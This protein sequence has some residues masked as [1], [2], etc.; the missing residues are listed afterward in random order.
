[1][2]CDCPRLASQQ[3][4]MNL[5]KGFPM[6]SNLKFWDTRCLLKVLAM[7]LMTA[8]CFG[9]NSLKTFD[10]KG[11]LLGVGNYQL[12]FKT[13]DGQETVAYL[14]ES[15]SSF[16]YKGTAEPTALSP[17]LM[18]RFTGKFDAKGN[19]QSDLEELQIFSPTFNP[20]LN[21]EQQLTQTPGIYPVD[22]KAPGAAKQKS[23]KGKR[24]EQGKADINAAQEYRVVGKIS[25]I[26][27]NKIQVATPEKALVVKLSS[28]ANISIACS[29][30]TFCKPGDE[31]HVVGLTSAEQPNQVQAKTVRITGAKPF[32][33]KVD[34]AQ[35]DAAKSTGAQ[36]ND[37][38]LQINNSGST[39]TKSDSKRSTSKS[40]KNRS[41]SDDDPATTPSKK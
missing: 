28:K 14:S 21:P 41:K 40:S 18:V 8:S 36:T 22:S 4:L 7:C 31:V 1:M 6:R 32:S 26:Q 34:A 27:G 39:P 23:S 24:N 33:A 13:K 5:G 25:A 10:S 17:G 30:L 11:T 15:T 37:S 20:S 38:A 29:N 16:E 12:F 35:V 9:Q 3:N 2:T 19:L